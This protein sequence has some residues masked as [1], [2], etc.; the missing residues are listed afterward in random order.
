MTFEFELHDS[1]TGAT[2]WKCYYSHDEL[3][4]GKD[5]PA[6]VAALNRNVASGLGDLSEGLNQYFSTH[7][8]VASSEGH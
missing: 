4:D 1:T 2:V 5:V 8:A 3:V 6:V 7:R